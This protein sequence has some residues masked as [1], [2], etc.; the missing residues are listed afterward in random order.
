MKKTEREEQRKALLETL[1]HWTDE[2]AKAKE[3]GDAEQFQIS[4][5]QR[6]RTLAELEKL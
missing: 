2:R 5:L 1:R 3:E 6:T 4:E